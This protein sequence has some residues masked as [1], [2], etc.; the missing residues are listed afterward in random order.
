M[1]GVAMPILYQAVTVPR[2]YHWQTMALTP[3]HNL[4]LGFWRDLVAKAEAATGGLETVYAFTTDSLLSEHLPFSA[5]GLF[6]LRIIQANAIVLPESGPY[7]ALGNASGSLSA[8]FVRRRHGFPYG[9]V[10][11]GQNGSVA[12]A[13]LSG[14]ESFEQLPWPGGGESAWVAHLN[15]VQLQSLREQIASLPLP[16]RIEDLLEFEPLL[17]DEPIV[18]GETMHVQ[19]RWHVLENPSPSADY[20]FFVHLLG[21]GGVSKAYITESPAPIGQW[22]QGEVGLASFALAIPSDIEPGRYDLAVGLYDP[23]T[24]TRLPIT[25]NTEVVGPENAVYLGPLKIP[26]P[27]P[28]PIP[29]PDALGVQPTFENKLALVGVELDESVLRLQWKALMPLS[30][31][32]TRFAHVVDGGGRLRWQSDSDPL[33]G[34]YPTSIWEEGEVV[35]EQL[36]LPSELRLDDSWRLVLG[37]Y[38]Q[39]GLVRLQRTAGPLDQP[40]DRIEVPLGV[41]QRP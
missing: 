41:L 4:P 39:D 20:G 16:W 18:P 3:F 2:F 30:E 34:A 19:V 1:M 9:E 7:T 29:M 32:L 13:Q 27:R 40:A 10:Y 25:S 21:R 12:A 15:D 6:A 26:A 24:N 31:D 36:R 22:R 35:E 5:K 8:D 33:E 38:R 37:W 14:F 11:A 23:V 17:T 28:S